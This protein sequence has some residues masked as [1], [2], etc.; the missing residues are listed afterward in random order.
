VAL[1]ASTDCVYKSLKTRVQAQFK[2]HQAFVAAN[3][4]S[5]AVEPGAITTTS[6]MVMHTLGKGAGI[7]PVAANHAGTCG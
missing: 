1:E 7:T 2:A 4:A 5:A 3:L 6:G